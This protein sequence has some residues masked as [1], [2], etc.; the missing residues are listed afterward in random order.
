MIQFINYMYQFFTIWSL[1]LY[2]IY[3]LIKNNIN[4]TIPIY[5]TNYIISSIITVG[6][7]GSI[8][9]YTK[10]NSIKQVF[11][12]KFKINV[13]NKIIYLFDLL[14]HV[15]P[16]IHIL[17]NKNKFINTSSKSNNSFYK[18]LLILAVILLIYLPNHNISNI[19]FNI[20]YYKLLIPSF[21]I[22]IIQ[23]YL[24]NI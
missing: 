4:Y 21:S 19:Y 7:I 18:S 16:L 10:I 20:N 9:T 12:N 17:I 3:L 24:L 8:I 14:V 6:I 13:D 2:I 22:F 15:L 23:L 1:T 5:I 11:F